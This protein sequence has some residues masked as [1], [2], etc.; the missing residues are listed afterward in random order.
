[1]LDIDYLKFALSGLQE[2]PRPDRQVFAS[3]GYDGVL[4]VLSN[5]RAAEFPCVVLEDR[6]TG[7]LGYRPGGYD[8]YNKVLW[9]MDQKGRDEREGEAY[10]RAFTLVK[11]VVRI[12][13]R[14]RRHR[15]PS[16]DIASIPYSRRQGG[17]A[18]YGY[19]LILSFQEDIDLTYEE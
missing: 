10:A 5:V 11:K 15:F 2:F 19:E 9:V 1:M 4:A 7:E 6:S 12:L 14:D 18:C 8:T 16:L 3:D 17:V 13:A